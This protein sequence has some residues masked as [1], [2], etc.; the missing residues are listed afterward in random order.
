LKLDKAAKKR[1][2]AQNLQKL[3]T[4][5]HKIKW[6]QTRNI[7]NVTFYETIKLGTVNNE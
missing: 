3:K 5:C 2:R 6:L 4:A 7:W 1:K